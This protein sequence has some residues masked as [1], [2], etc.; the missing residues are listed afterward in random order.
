MDNF[1]CRRLSEAWF[2]QLTRLLEGGKESWFVTFSFPFN[3][4]RPVAEEKLKEWIRRL[5]Q[6]LD[7]EEDEI[8]CEYVL[9]EQIREVFHIHAVVIARG[10]SKLDQDRWENKWTEITGQ[11]KIKNCVKIRIHRHPG[12]I[13]R[14]DGEERVASSVIECEKEITNTETYY[15]GGG[16]CR[17]EPIQE[18]PEGYTPPGVAGYI[19]ARHSREV[20]SDMQFIGRAIRDF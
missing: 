11:K 3:V 5:R 2:L 6:A 20:I 10:L 18:N 8:F 19:V 17:V 16:T 15:T 1:R 7:L 13:R 9:A 12:V 14:R 4:R